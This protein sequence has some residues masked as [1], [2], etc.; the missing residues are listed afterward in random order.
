VGNLIAQP[1]VFKCQGTFIAKSRNTL[2]VN[3]G[4]QEY[5]TLCIPSGDVLVHSES[6]VSGISFLRN[7]KEHHTFDNT[8]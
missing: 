4:T 1:G 3:Y 2:L 6:M 7:V 8:T 5:E